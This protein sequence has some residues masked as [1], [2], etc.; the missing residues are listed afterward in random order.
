MVKLT[1]QEEQVMIAIWQTGEG[2]I[3]AFM[4]NMTDPGPYTTVASTVKNIEKKGYITSKLYGNVYVYKPAISRE[5]YKKMFMG[6]VVKDYFS[7]SYKE[8][9]SFFVDQKKLSAKELKE[10]ME[11]IEGGRPPKSSKGGR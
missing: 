6:N 7:N 9:V 10:I 1:A 5:E 4:E 8:L 11:M 2:H 3:K